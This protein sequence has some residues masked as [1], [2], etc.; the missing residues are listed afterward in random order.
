[1][2]LFTPI[3]GKDE[4]VLDGG[5]VLYHQ[6]FLSQSESLNYFNFLDTNVNWQQTQISMYGKTYDLPRLTA[7]YGD[8]GTEYK[9]S[10]IL[11]R[12]LPWISELLILK[13]KIERICNCEFN[14]LLLNKYRSGLDK[15]SWHQDNEKEFGV[16]PIIASLSLG[17][18]RR[19]DI[20][21]LAN[22]KVKHSFQL[23]AGSL[24][25]M[26]GD[27]QQNWEHQIPVQKKILAPRIN[28]TFRKVLI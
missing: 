22:T 6:H 9:Y 19:F 8:E 13:E 18:E 2:D 17:A 4:F 1:M 5:E 26:K 25:V 28:L 15:V 21:N 20:R 14:S 12:P 16:N 11:N 24:I 27:F 10:G 3:D 23:S 7:W